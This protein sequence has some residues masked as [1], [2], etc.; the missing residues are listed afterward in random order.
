MVTTRIARVPGSNCPTTSSPACLVGNATADV[1]KP[2]LLRIELQGTILAISYRGAAGVIVSTSTLPGAASRESLNCQITLSHMATQRTSSGSEASLREKLRTNEKVR[3][4]FIEE[5]VS[6]LAF[7]GMAV[8]REDAG[9]WLNEVLE[10]PPID[11]T[12]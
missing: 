12:A 10:E 11:V 3:G 8:S 1:S 5:I 9:R 6:S 7:E 2:S 4:E